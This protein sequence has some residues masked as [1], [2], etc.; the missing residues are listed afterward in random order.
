MNCMVPEIGRRFYKSKKV[1]YKVCHK[2]ENY[3][4]VKRVR[5]Q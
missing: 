1:G 4:C 5:F 2:G 3:I